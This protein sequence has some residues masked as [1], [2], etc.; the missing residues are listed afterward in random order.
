[1]LTDVVAESVIYR[2]VS[3]CLIELIDAQSKDKLVAQAE[4]KDPVFLVSVILAALL[5]NVSCS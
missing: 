1:M 2:P 3:L 4:A 5:V